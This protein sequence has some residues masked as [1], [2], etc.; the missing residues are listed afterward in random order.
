MGV[1][2]RP[3]RSR[4][5]GMYQ[6]CMGPRRQGGSAHAGLPAHRWAARDYIHTINF[7][8]WVLKGVGTS[9][10]ASKLWYREHAEFHFELFIE[11]H[12]KEYIDEEEKQ[13]RFE[14]FVENM[15]KANQMNEQSDHAVFGITQFSDLT[16]E[17]FVNHYTGLDNSFN[18]TESECNDFYDSQIPNYNA[19]ESFDWRQ[20]NAVSRVKNQGQCGGCYAFSASGNIEGQYAIKHGSLIEL[21]EQQIIDCDKGSKGCR[22]GSMPA[23]FRSIIQQGGIETEDDYPYEASQSYCR[24]TPGIAAVRLTDC[25]LYSLRSQ[26][27]LKQLLYHNGPISIGVQ[28]SSFQGYHGGIMSDEHCNSGDVN[29]GVLLVGYGTENGRPFWTV[30]NSWGENFGEHGYIRIQR[31]DSAASCGMMNNGLMSSSVVM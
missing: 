13:F 1:V 11:E 5:A 25:N 10:T 29:H 30:K 8:N 6:E 23:S 24:F 3:T 21:S 4:T 14:I 22:G 15:L 26:E 19:P 12:N 20:H 28:A 17:E 9:K 2:R 18:F 27:K 31:G 16:P 7:E